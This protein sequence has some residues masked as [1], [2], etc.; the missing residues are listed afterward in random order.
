MA[1][2]LKGGT[3]SRDGKSF[4]HVSEREKNMRNKI[5]SAVLRSERILRKILKHKKVHFYNPMNR[6]S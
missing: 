1:E 2:R 3:G 6:V 5:E 4:L